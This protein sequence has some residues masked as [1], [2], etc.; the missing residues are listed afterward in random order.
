MEI[1]YSV[2]I[3]CGDRVISFCLY[4]NALP[5]RSCP[6]KAQVQ[7][8]EGPEFC[9]LSCLGH[10]LSFATPSRYFREQLSINAGTGLS[11]WA[12]WGNRYGNMLQPWVGISF[13]HRKGKNEPCNISRFRFCF[14]ILGT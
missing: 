5:P 3:K 2:G 4:V 1:S 12:V 13:V 14:L 10:Q 11:L 7:E 8:V 9:V 6:E